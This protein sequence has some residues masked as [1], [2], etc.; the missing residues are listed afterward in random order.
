MK[1]E[2]CLMS[3]DKTE[4]IFIRVSPTEKKE[5]EE[6]ASLVNKSVANYLITLSDNK[7]VVDTSKLPPLILEIKRIGVNVNQIAAVANSQ[8]FIN[9]ELLLRVDKDL[10]EVIKLLQQILEEVYNT[11]EHT[12]QSLETKIDK[13]TK[14]VERIGDDGS[15]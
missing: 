2:C 3:K 15:S 11:E 13:L 6:K 9:K 12:L 5:I 1:G 8:K 10:K 4:R 7:R 14:A